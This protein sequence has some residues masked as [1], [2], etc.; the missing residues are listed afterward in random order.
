M[1]MKTESGTWIARTETQPRKHGLDG[2]IEK[3]R[4]IEEE[5][6]AEQK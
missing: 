2:G 4:Q 1:N 6:R 5:T 3:T